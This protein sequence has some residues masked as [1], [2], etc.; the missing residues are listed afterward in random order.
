MREFTVKCD[1][2]GFQ[3][4]FNADEF[5]PVVLDGWAYINIRGP[6]KDME[7]CPECT[8]NII[9]VKEAKEDD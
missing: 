4:T 6:Y 9:D 1:N 5:E 8:K 2:C 3:K 7:I